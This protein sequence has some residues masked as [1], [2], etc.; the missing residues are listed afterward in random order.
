MAG[1]EHLELTS[2]LEG[3]CQTISHLEKQE[4]GNSYHR[5]RQDKLKT[6]MRS[7]KLGGMWGTGEARRGQETHGS[8]SQSEFESSEPSDAGFAMKKCPKCALYFPL[9]KMAE[10]CRSCK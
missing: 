6:L 2:E 1:A 7:S 10:H 8:R 5:K 3:I 4:L 9:E